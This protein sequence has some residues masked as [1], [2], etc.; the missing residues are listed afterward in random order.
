MT[1]KLIRKIKADDRGEYLA[2]VREFYSSDAV[3][4][5]VPDGYILGTFDEVIRSDTYASAYFLVSGGVTAGY[6]LTARSY[7]QEAGGMV[8]WIEEIYIKPEFRGKG[9]G[10]EFFAMAKEQLGKGVARIRLEAEP[11]NSRAVA[12]Y[13]RLGFTDLPY[14]QMII[15]RRKNPPDAE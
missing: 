10:S 13:R 8:L 12:L 11:E 2:M 9:L 15:E 4:H 7:S 1:G 6:A 3:L 5:A 14:S